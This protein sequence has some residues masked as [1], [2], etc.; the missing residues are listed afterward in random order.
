MDKALSGTGRETFE[1]VKMMQAIQK[2]GYTAANGAK[3]PG[4]RLGQSMKQ[5][6]QLIKSDIGLEVA[7]TDVGGWDTHVNEVGQ[8]PSCLASLP[9]C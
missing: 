5:I 7:F 4:G 1:A 3:Y 8:K 6:A 2:Q 9:T